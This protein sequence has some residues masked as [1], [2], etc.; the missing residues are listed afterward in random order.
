MLRSNGTQ[1]KDDQMKKVFTVVAVQ[2]LVLAVAAGSSA[3]ASSSPSLNVRRTDI[4][5]TLVDGH[6]RTLYMFERDRRDM[7]NCSGVC[8]TVWPAMTTALKP[9]AAGGAIGAKVGTIRSHGQR[10]VT[11]AGHP[12]YYY[13]GDRKAGDVNGE[14]LNQFGGKWYALSP[15]GKVIDR[16]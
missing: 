14:G 10:Q 4:G 1:F 16:D 7:S 2:T 13:V 8:L 9:H 5:R 3:L 6:G 11:Y 15:S 12:V